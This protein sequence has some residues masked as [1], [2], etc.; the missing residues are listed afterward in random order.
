MKSTRLYEDKDVVFEKFDDGNYRITFFREDNH[1]G[2]DI[3][4]NKKDG[5]ILDDVKDD[6][7]ARDIEEE[8]Q[9]IKADL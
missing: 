5:V 8:T 4:F 2:G 9:T 1:W 3:T 6:E 7:F